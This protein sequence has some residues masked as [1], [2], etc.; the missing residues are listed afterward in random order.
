MYVNF[1]QT[2][3]V[4][5]IEQMR[6]IDQ[7]RLRRVERSTSSENNRE[8]MQTIAEI[9]NKAFGQKLEQKKT[10]LALRDHILET[11]SAEH[12]QVYDSVSRSFEASL[13]NLYVPEFITF[14]TWCSSSSKNSLSNP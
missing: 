9:Q 14:V 1:I 8:R 5:T 2:M 4:S 3:I 6:L 11:P 13:H 10:S 7:I 12:L